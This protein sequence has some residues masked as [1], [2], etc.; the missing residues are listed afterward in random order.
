MHKIIGIAGAT[1]VAKGELFF[2]TKKRQPNEKQGVEPIKKLNIESARV[3]CVTNMQRLYEKTLESLGEKEAKIFQ[4]YEMLLEDPLLFA[5][6]QKSI[7]EGMEAEEAITKE[8][9]TISRIFEKMNDEYMQQ[10]GEDIRHVGEMLL[11]EIR[12]ENVVIELPN[13]KQPILLVAE[14]LSPAETMNMD[15]TRLLGIVTEKGGITSHTVI[16]SKSLGIPAVVGAVGIM[17]Y[18]DKYHAAMGLL[19][20]E[21]GIL[22]CNPGEEEE[23]EFLNRQREEEERRQATKHFQHKKATTK[24]GIVLHILANIGKPEDLEVL[25][26]TYYD[27]VGLY[28]SEFLYVDGDKKPTFEEQV[29]AYQHVIEE[30]YPHT[31]TIRTL[32]IGGD[33]EVAYLQLQK[34]ENPFLGN[35]GIR[36]CLEKDALFKEQ[37]RAIVTAARGRKV[38]IMFPMITELAEIQKA[39]TWLREI[40]NE[41]GVQENSK[42]EMGIMIET[43]AAAIMADKYSNYCDFFS[44]GTND[45]VQYLTC[46]DRGNAQV[47][48][49]YNPYHPAVLQIL[50]QVIRQE[51][52][53]G[54]EVSVCGDIAANEKY[55]PLLL[56]LGLRK[57]SVPC[58]LVNHMKERLEKLDTQEMKELAKLALEMDSAKEI[59]ALY[60]DLQSQRK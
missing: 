46:A 58:A 1:G 24:D 14:E 56:G 11:A 40:E 41:L 21:A 34:E 2:Y 57:I 30:I 50:W 42:A 59:E 8:C 60:R 55:L 29:S 43:P 25:S 52:E 9:E 37:L 18:K 20:G 13:G 35:R 22:I 5:P 39:D 32:D 16:L 7:E 27:G 31:A 53:R 28:R 15:I 26:N 17:N 49:V 19:D 23:Q 44:I 47:A 51:E 36:L 48:Q 4:A 3:K 6:I 38:K 10:R 33:K 54:I 45:L 12:R